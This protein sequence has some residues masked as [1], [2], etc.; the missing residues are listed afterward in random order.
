M[1]NPK[2]GP[3]RPFAKGSSGNPKGRPKVAPQ[4]AEAFRAGGTAEDLAARAWALLDDPKL[5]PGERVAVI[6]LIGDRGWGKPLSTLD[7]MM[8]VT[9]RADAPEEL[10]A[11]QLADALTAD[12]I[13]QLLAM[14]RKLDAAHEPTMEVL[15]LPPRATALLADAR[16][17]HH[18]S[19]CGL[20]GRCD[21][22]CSDLEPGRS[23][24][25]DDALTDG[26]ASDCHSSAEGDSAQLGEILD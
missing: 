13:R 21:A 2:P 18:D 11:E 17:R 24:G 23:P 6:A 3:G 12:E 1:A 14:R 8:D 20:T 16:P 5:K 4:L 9:A 10:T 22:F 26:D 15:A 25:T 19:L 7:I